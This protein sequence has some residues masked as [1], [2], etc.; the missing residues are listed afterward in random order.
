MK[1]YTYPIEYHKDKHRGIAGTRNALLRYATADY[2]M[3]CDA[4][5]MFCS[6]I[7]IYSILLAINSPDGFDELITY[8][9]SEGYRP[10]GSIRYAENTRVIHPF[11]HGKVYNRKYLVENSIWYCEDVD[12]HEDVYFSFLA[13]SCAT[14]IK[15]LPQYAYIWKTSPT[16][17]TRQSPDF[18][19]KNYHD[20]LR[21][22]GFVADEL[23]KRNKLEDA[24][25]Y[26]TC[27]LFN[28]YTFM[29]T[30]SWLEHKGDDMWIDAENWL[31]WLW[32]K[33]GNDLFN[34]Y[35]PERVQKIWDDT[36]SNAIKEG[37][38]TKEDLEQPF[39]EWLQEILDRHTE[40]PIE[41]ESEPEETT[42]EETSEEE[43]KNS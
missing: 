2:V 30:K 28:T 21:A 34:A 43:D 24:K 37:A 19:I 13:H 27:C 1:T 42:E 17:I 26:Y 32:Q 22:I 38:L 36:M 18:A 31:C 12:Y 15:Q 10:D 25:F 20:S 9:Y 8:F 11:I 5:D 4:D 14:N 29:H 16:S 3:F 33:H 41:K 35:D 23:I 40:K 6:L 7:A 39:N